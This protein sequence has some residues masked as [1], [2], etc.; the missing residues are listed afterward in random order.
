M[1]QITEDQY[2]KAKE[3]EPAIKSYLASFS[4]VPGGI[5]TITQFAVWHNTQVESLQNQI[6]NLRNELTK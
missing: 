3:I 2:I 5:G 4:V 1:I 6:D